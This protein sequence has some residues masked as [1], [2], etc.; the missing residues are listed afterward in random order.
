MLPCL[1]ERSTPPAV[2]L[3][4]VIESAYNELVH[5]SAQALPPRFGSLPKS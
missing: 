3:V 5:T 2:M 4:V 1:K